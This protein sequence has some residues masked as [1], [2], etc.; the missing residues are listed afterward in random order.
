MSLIAWGFTRNGTSDRIMKSAG[1]PGV[2]DPLMAASRDAWA[3]RVGWR[4]RFRHPR[5]WLSKF[6]DA[7]VSALMFLNFSGLGHAG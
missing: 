4:P 2:I 7:P 5:R 3:S 6:M 1:L